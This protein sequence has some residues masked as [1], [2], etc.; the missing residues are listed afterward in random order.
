MTS[1]R[2]VELER[3]GKTFKGGTVALRDINLEVERGEVFGL[4][5]PNGA[6]KSTTIR[7]MLDLLRPTRGRV[8]LFGQDP[9]RA[10][11]DL[12]RRIGYLPGELHLDERLSAR[13]TLAW[14]SRLRRMPD[15]SYAVGLADRFDLPLDRGIRELSRGNKQKIGLIQAMMHRPELLILDEPTSGLDPILQREFVELVHDVS[16]E[17]VTSFISS[18]VLSELEHVANRVGMV[19]QG[20]LLA[21]EGIGALKRHSAHRV[22]IRFGGDIPQD[23]FAGVEGISHLEISGSLARMR[24]LGSMDEVV[25]VAARHEVLD[26]T[27]VEP[28]LEEIFLAYYGACGEDGPSEDGSGDTR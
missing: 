20:A 4:I 7:L 10:G 27:S 17:G 24:V 21:V 5:G 23:L 9:R 15:L 14:F 13:E 19:R 28:D 3:L 11:P 12:R 22:A 16:S 25:K 18:H 2:A 1:S 8:L 6:G 26:L